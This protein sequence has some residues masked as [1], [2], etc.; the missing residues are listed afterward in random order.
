M[1][2]SP[3]E[4]THK[5]RVPEVLVK[6]PHCYRDFPT[7]A[8]PGHAVRC[9]HCEGILSIPNFA[10]TSGIRDEDDEPTSFVAPKEKGTMYWFLVGVCF[11]FC[12]VTGYYFT[13][14][15]PADVTAK[16]LLAWLIGLGMG[17]GFT[18]AKLRP[19]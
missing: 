8:R 6:C 13:G 11:T 16:V 19:S 9:P 5:M 18:V 17:F 7:D 3:Y 10:Q 1:D 14:H 12:V 4:R 15:Y 2:M